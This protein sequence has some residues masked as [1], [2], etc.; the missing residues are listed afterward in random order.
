[1]SYFNLQFPVE[2]K[3]TCNL[4]KA[5]KPR[6]MF[7]TK[8]NQTGEILSVS[9]CNICGVVYLYPK[10]KRSVGRDYFENAYNDQSDSPAH[11]YFSDEP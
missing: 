6:L 3:E 8:C 4:C 11:L 2:E 7:K 5:G 1:M 10:P 9:R